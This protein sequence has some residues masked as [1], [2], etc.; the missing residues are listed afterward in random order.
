MVIG[1]TNKTI[2]P[3]RAKMMD[4]RLWWL[5]CRG[6][7]KQFCYYWDA[8][9]RI[10]PITVL[11]TIQTFIT[12]PTILHMQAYGMSHRFPHLCS[13]H[14]RVPFLSFYFTRSKWSLQGCVDSQESLTGEDIPWFSGITNKVTRENNTDQNIDRLIN[15]QYLLPPIKLFYTQST[16]LNLL[17]DHFSFLHVSQVLTRDLFASVESE[18]GWYISCDFISL[19][20]QHHIF[21]REELGLPA[22]VAVERC[23]CDCLFCESVTYTVELLDQC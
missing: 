18:R 5:R 11:N 23:C 9:Q 13:H 14:N 2:V 21:F 8:G 15:W 16:A 19:F 7:R 22:W 6:S 10:G 20:Y 1:V 4:M 12:K 17:L 3:K